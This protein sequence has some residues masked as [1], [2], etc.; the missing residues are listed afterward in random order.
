MI[1]PKALWISPTGRTIPVEYLH[2]TEIINSPELFGYTLA[3]IRII[4]D[5]FNEPLGSEANARNEIMSDLIRKGWIRIRYVSK[6][7]SWTVQLNG[8]SMREVPIDLIK[9]LF[10]ALIQQNSNPRFSMIRIINLNE[11]ELLFRDIEVFLSEDC[12]SQ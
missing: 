4:H 1:T 5:K 12:L 3:E 9:N 8:D 11:S 10:S 7:D 2:I 6:H